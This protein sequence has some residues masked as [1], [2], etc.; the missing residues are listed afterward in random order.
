MLTFCP[1]PTTHS[2]QGSVPNLLW[3]RYWL[4]YDD[5]DD[6]DD[7]DGDGDGDDDDFNSAAT[8]FAGPDRNQ[9]FVAYLCIHIY[10]YIQICIYIYITYSINVY[11]YGGWTKHSCRR[12]IKNDL[13]PALALPCALWGFL[14]VLSN[15][16]SY[17]IRDCPG[18]VA[19]GGVWWFQCSTPF[20]NFN[21]SWQPQQGTCWYI[22]DGKPCLLIP[23]M[24][25]SMQNNILLESKTYKTIAMT[26]KRKS[27]LAP[28]LIFLLLA[29]RCQKLWIC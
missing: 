1:T 5:D 26:G 10:I 18:Y 22:P 8:V 7:D 2:H 12:V 9:A 11:V 4:G 21:S 28:W 3:T 15:K 20:C 19:Q 6:D 16:Y 23:V 13:A 24:K 27:V 29:K 25:V 14:S 17:L